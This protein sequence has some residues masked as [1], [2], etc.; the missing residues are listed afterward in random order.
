MDR[1]GRFVFQGHMGPFCVVDL[2]R[3]INHLPSLLKIFRAAQQQLHLEDSVD[4]LGQRVLVAVIPISHGALNIVP[5][6]Q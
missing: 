4:S 1:V 5:L 3:L 6:V 2:H